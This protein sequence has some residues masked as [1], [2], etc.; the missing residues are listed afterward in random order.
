MT[1]TVERNE[2]M[3]GSDDVTTDKTLPTRLSDGI[4][5]AISDLEKIE[6]SKL[7][8]VEMGD[9]YAMPDATESGLCEV[10]LAG[11]VMAQT[12]EVPIDDESTITP[13][14]FEPELESKLEAY[15]SLRSGDIGDAIRYWY[16]HDDQHN[17]I[18][19][20]YVNEKIVDAGFRN[21]SL[22]GEE[23]DDENKLDNGDLY[24]NTHDYDEDPAKFKSDLRRMAT[25]LRGIG[26]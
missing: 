16:M 23:P 3:Y 19:V 4:E 7:Y 13:D 9:W 17:P 22:A 18:D 25:V 5:L 15:D 1:T 26:L 14:S 24:Y 12:F 10:C 8:R 20:D 6:A 21:I 11:A 2:L